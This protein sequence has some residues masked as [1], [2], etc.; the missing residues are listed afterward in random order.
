MCERLQMRISEGGVLVWNHSCVE[1][2]LFFF[3][4]YRVNI[5]CKGSKVEYRQSLRERERGNAIF[6]L[7]EPEWWFQRT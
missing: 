7:S 2:E 5:Q 6:H 1:R 3:F 4:F